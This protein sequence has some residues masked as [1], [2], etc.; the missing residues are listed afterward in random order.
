MGFRAQ[1]SHLT[2]MADASRHEGPFGNCVSIFSI[3]QQIVKDSHTV[4][5][6]VHRF[7]V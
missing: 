5:V 2:L 6:D 3:I 7:E 4:Q 1:M